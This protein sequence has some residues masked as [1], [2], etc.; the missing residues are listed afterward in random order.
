VNLNSAVD[1]TR[2]Y[3][4]SA[5]LDTHFR[6]ATCAEVDCPQYLMGWKLRYDTLTEQQRYD[7]DHCGRRFVIEDGFAVFEA[8]QTCFAYRRHRTRLDIPEHFLVREGRGGVL[9][10]ASAEDWTDDLHTHTDKV[11]EQK[12]RG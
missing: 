11:S 1:L 7:V 6:Q 12:Q 2:R 9:T 3:R 4:I 10:H 5:P 8:G